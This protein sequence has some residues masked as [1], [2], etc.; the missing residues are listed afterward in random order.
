M[1]D[2]DPSVY[3]NSSPTVMGCTITNNGYGIY[4]NWSSSGTYQGNA[5]TD[6][7]YGIY[8]N[9]G[10]VNPVVNGNI[11]SGNTRDISAAGTITGSVIWDNTEQANTYEISNL[12]VAAG[13]SLTIN[14]GKTVKLTGGAHIEVVSTLTASGVTFT[15][16]DGQT[17]W[18]GIRFLDVG[19]SG[20]R[21]DGCVF[22]HAR[23]AYRYCSDESY[24]TGVI[25]I[26]NSSPTITSCTI[27]NSSA[28]AGIW[29]RCQSSPSIANCTINGFAD[30]RSG[31]MV[32]YDPSVYGNSSPIVTG[33]TI[34]GNQ[35]GIFINN[36]SG[37][38]YQGNTI[39][40]NDSYGL[41]Y[42]GN[43]IIDATHSYWGDP[44]GPY[45]PSDDRASGGL[46]NPNGLGDMV[47]DHVNYDPWAIA[48]DTDNDGFTDDED[49][50]PTKPNGPDLGTC[51][52][53]SDKPGITCT[54]DAD[55]VEG[56]SS[57]GLCIK[58]QRDTDGDGF[59]DVCD[60]CPNNC[61]VQ[62]LDADGDS[63]GDV[64]D[65]TP[66]CG[67]CDQPQCEQECS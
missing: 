59:G 55:C 36:S 63:K 3:G 2:Y 19:S 29:I 18:N 53:G 33:C 65:T 20:S 43:N 35:Y 67:I 13:A 22:E 25:S 17:E 23:G 47:S 12:T 49:N 30:N 60:N 41:F 51:S 61:N 39:T 14:P 37:G 10:L 42:S 5:I 4:I 24:N 21:L 64:C 11:C 28:I 32:D 9:Y 54:S 7:V 48:P 46:Y 45:D 31:I 50:C 44:S 38:I 8:I 58:D 52:S 26:W 62:Q 1:V 57:N 34:T 27:T 56:C 66:W 15:W 6:N 40:N 16:A